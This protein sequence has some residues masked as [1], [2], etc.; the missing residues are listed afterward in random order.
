MEKATFVNDNKYSNVTGAGSPL[1]YGVRENRNKA[2]L[3]KKAD[4]AYEQAEYD[5][6]MAKIKLDQAISQSDIEKATAEYEQAKADSRKAKMEQT[7]ADLEQKDLEYQAK[8]LEEANNPTPTPTPTPSFM[9]KNKNYILI[10]G[11]LLVGAFLYF[12]KK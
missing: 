11:A 8:K 12:R 2:L 6:K 4:A 3:K 1:F 10:G 5:K 9:E 7:K